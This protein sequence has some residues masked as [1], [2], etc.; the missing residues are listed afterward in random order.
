MSLTLLW[1]GY[2]V[3]P[4]VAVQ[5][6]QTKGGDVTGF[7]VTVAHI[8]ELCIKRNLN[9]QAIV[10]AIFHE[11][12]FLRSWRWKNWRNPL[13]IGI[14]SKSDE[15]VWRPHIPTPI[16]IASMAVASWYQKVHGLPAT[17]S[18]FPDA[19]DVPGMSA[20]L[21]RSWAFTKMAN[22][23]AP[24]RFTSDMREPFIDE[25]GVQQYV[26]AEDQRW[27]SGVDAIASNLKE[28]GALMETDVATRIVHGNV[29]HPLYVDRTIPD[30]QNGAWDDLGPCE[31]WG[32][33]YHT[34]VGTLM[35]TDGWFRRGASST[36][37]THYGIGGSSDGEYDGVIFMWNDPRGR[38]RSD[39]PIVGG[40]VSPNR[41]G[42]ANGGSDGLEGDGV[43]FVRKYGVAPIN[44]N[45]VSIE[46]SDGGNILQKPSTK[47]LDAMIRLGAYWFDYAKVPYTTFPLN[48]A[49]D[50][51]TWLFHYEFATKGCPHQAV[52]ELVNVIQDRQRAILKAAQLQVDVDP[53]VPPVIPPKPNVDWPNGWTT[54]ELDRRFG[55][56]TRIWPDGTTREQGFNERGSISNAWVQ[57]AASEGIT[58]S[59]LIPRPSSWNVL[60]LDRRTDL[61]PEIVVFDA[62][63]LKNWLLYRP[64][65]SVSW[66]WVA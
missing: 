25:N 56:V 34:M 20:W 2:T 15:E 42:W 17:V 62:P 66:K 57:R 32:A 22:W 63:G 65:E 8:N 14:R 60:D 38:G 12:D 23:P 6:A 46:R 27:D 21:G 28:R 50:I 61:T 35:G 10:A 7:D 1:N 24:I 37:L 3:I 4:D 48:P 55:S 13:G 31:P 40:R 44:R 29:K 19:H 51:V 26:W 54:E 33:V 16:Q 11:T 9:A 58:K 47:Q 49:L 18:D 53:E 59:K 45:L 43:A 39:A 64:D 36:G 5:T 41:A 30:W 52:I